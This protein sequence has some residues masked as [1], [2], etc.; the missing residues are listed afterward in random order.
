MNATV[1]N[2]A[3]FQ[4]ARARW[5][6]LFEA[7]EFERA[8][9][10]VEEALPWAA[11]S[12]DAVLYDRAR[13]NRAAIAL[14]LGR[15]GDFA[16]LLREVLMRNEDAENSFLAAYTLA[17]HYELRKESKKGL[18]Y[19]QLASDRA[20]ALD[21]ARRASSRN[22]I[23]NLLVAESRFAEAAEIY[24]QALA[25]L[26]SRH[27]LRG[28][29]IAYNLGY[30]EVMVG[31]VREGL[32]ELYASLRALLGLGAARHEMKARLDL[33]FALL[34]AGEAGHAERHAAR[35]ERL[36]ERFADQEAR[37]NALY[38]RGAAAQA[39]GDRFAARRHFER[40]Q[41]GFYPDAEYLPELLSQVDVRSLVNLK[42]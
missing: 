26:P 17:R 22:H 33:A 40:L 29:V 27:E 7:G 42:A 39:R 20:E 31:R 41:A 19:A 16:P 11:A 36:A 37:K 9:A 4:A 28:A 18:F 34:E 10:L 15:G 24:R 6:E 8:L 3:E 13:C 38:L 35:A 23:A 2:A 14:E 32:G 12:G 25:M 30:C 1:T 5:V 21:A